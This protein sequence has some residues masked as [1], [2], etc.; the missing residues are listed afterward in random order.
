M[1]LFVLR[2][3][4]GMV[5]LLL[6]ATFII[7]AAVYALPGDPIRA[8]AGPTTEISP[9]TRA[10][11]TEEYHLDEPLLVQY[12]YYVT[13]VFRGDLGVDLRGSP[14]S[15]WSRPPGRSPCSWA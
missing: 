11:L 3:V 4:L 1:G 10:A 2:R 12:W 7:F 8:I 9:A 5:P 6:G 13:G 15:T 14:C